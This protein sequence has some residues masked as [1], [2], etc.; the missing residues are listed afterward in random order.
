[1]V[2][3]PDW[4]KPQ[5]I[6]GRTVAHR[7]RRGR[8]RPQIPLPI[9]V[10]TPGL[11]TGKTLPLF[12]RNIGEDK[13]RIE[14]IH[15]GPITT[16][17][18]PD[19]TESP[20][21]IRDDDGF[22]IVFLED[23]TWNLLCEIARERGSTLDELCGDIELNFAPGEAFAPAARRIAVP[24]MIANLGDHASRRLLEVLRCIAAGELVG[25][26]G[27]LLEEFIDLYLVCHPQ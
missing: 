21:Y 23:A 3:A 2:T 12:F 27:L 24:A 7:A 1:M 5:P 20:R 16:P 14:Q 10:L 11:K 17:D 6:T 22:D 4:V 8:G 15:I 9:S 18:C 13:V 19:P 26:A 25:R